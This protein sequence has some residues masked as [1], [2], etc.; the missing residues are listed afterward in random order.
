MTDLE[1]IK[2]CLAGYSDDFR[3]LVRR[4]ERPLLGYLINRLGE[5]Q[6]AQ[7][8]AQES[9]VR[10]YFGLSKLRK[11]ELFHS[12]L[13][14]IASRVALEFHRSKQRCLESPEDVSA[15]PALAPEASQE[16]RLDE[17][18]AA[19]TDSQ[20]QVVMLRYYEEM[21]CQQIADRLQMPLG[22]VTKT[23]SRA[24]IGLRD[25]LEKADPGLM[26]E[27]L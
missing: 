18:I 26:E 21:S 17:A 6:R 24:Y 8:A 3:F 27:R 1:L 2:R 7:E 10:A 13:L 20:R 16:Y 5:R 14:G 22:T 12:W 23:L 15:T 19:L 9:L 25:E 4:Y 11:P